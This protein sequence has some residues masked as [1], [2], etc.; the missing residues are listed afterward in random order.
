MYKPEQERK[1]DRGEIGEYSLMSRLGL[2]FINIF[3][4][5]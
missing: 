1:K 2:G 4:S 3:E 5:H